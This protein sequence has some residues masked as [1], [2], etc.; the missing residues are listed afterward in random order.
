MKTHTGNI[1]MICILGLS[2]QHPNVMVHQQHAGQS[3]TAQVPVVTSTPHTPRP[4]TPRTP[5]TTNPTP[6]LKVQGSE[7]RA[8]ALV[9]GS[10]QGHSVTF[11]LDLKEHESSKGGSVDEGEVRRERACK[12]KRYKEIVAESGM[13]LAK[14]ERKVVSIFTIVFGM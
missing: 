12:G 11:D 7:G 14:K 5:A 4:T 2:V 10:S 6:V 1:Y 9:T 3:L 8:Q 13:K